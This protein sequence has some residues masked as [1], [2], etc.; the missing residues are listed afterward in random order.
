MYVVGNSLLLGCIKSYK[1]S[2]HKKA[3]SY[4]AFKSQRKILKC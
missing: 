3:Y 2:E 4:K 1:K